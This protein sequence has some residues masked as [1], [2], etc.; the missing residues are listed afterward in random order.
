MK[1]N[2]RAASYHS[3]IYLPCARLHQQR[4]KLSLTPQDTG[5]PAACT[6][7]ADTPRAYRGSQRGGGDHVGNRSYASNTH[8]PKTK[9]LVDRGTSPLEISS[10]YADLLP[11]P[12]HT[13][14]Y[15]AD[16]QRC[17]T[18]VSAVAREADRNTNANVRAKQEDISKL[19]Y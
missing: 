9:Q 1:K 18:L 5:T 4:P 3:T 17:C 19:L 15:A 7:H 16:R 6:S 10:M 11:S 12:V 2:C 13:P 14:T 8:R